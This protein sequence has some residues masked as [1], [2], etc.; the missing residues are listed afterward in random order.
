MFWLLLNWKPLRDWAIWNPYN[1]VNIH[2][3]MNHWLILV[4]TDRLIVDNK[5]HLGSISAFHQKM[6]FKELFLHNKGNNTS[7]PCL[8]E[9]HVL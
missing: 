9:V 8:V 2:K 5:R 4:E 3:V 6:L 7:K 1:P